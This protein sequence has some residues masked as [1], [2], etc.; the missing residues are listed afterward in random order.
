LLGGVLLS[1]VSMGSLTGTSSS[2]SRLIC[3]LQFSIY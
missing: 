1:N 2:R 3:N